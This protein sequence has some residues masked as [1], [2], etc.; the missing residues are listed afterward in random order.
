MCFPSQLASI[1]E[2]VVQGG[3]A[4]APEQLNNRNEEEPSNY[5]PDAQQ[6]QFFAGLQERGSPPL[7]GVPFLLDQQTLCTYASASYHDHL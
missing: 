6:C 5:W 4:A 2:C 7:Q 1:L 3:T